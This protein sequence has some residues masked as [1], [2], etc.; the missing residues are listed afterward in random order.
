MPAAVEPLPVPSA[1]APPV[2]PLREYTEPSVLMLRQ[3]GYDGLNLT[4]GLASG[5]ACP[6]AVLGRLRAHGVVRDDC[7]CDV[8][9]FL[10]AMRNETRHLRTMQG[11]LENWDPREDHWL[12]LGLS[13]LMG[14]V[15]FWE[16]PTFSDRAVRRRL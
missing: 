6:A 7:V 8:F 12:T 14:R 11:L 16:V 4:T 15:P 10:I 2:L 13:L 9:R 3:R 5:F 1:L